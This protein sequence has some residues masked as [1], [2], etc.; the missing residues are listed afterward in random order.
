MTT[1]TTTTHAVTISIST[2][3]AFTFKATIDVPDNQDEEEYIGEV[4]SRLENAPFLD[5][6]YTRRPAIII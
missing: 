1:P 5:W 2:P 4:M 3:E 6:D